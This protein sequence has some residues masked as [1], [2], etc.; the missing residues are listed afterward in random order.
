MAICWDCGEEYETPDLITRESECPHCAAY[1]RC[2][3]NCGF[4]DP[5]AHNACREPQAELVGDKEVANAC[6]Y[7][8]SR[9]SHFPAGSGAKKAKKD[10]DDLF[11]D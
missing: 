9:G 2:C 7:F 1:L 3:K 8:R 6:D 11:K 4:Y 10:F 5:A